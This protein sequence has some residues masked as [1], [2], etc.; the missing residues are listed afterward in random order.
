MRSAPFTV[1]V[2][3]FVVAVCAATATGKKT[4]AAYGYQQPY[5]ASSFGQRYTNEFKTLVASGMKALKAG[6]SRGVAILMR[7][8]KLKLNHWPNYELWDD[9]AVAECKRGEFEA[10]QWLLKSYRCAVNIWQ[11]RTA[12]HV[13]TYPNVVPNADLPPLCFRTFCG[14]VWQPARDEYGPTEGDATRD[15]GPDELERVDALLKSCRAG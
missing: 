2:L 3:A 1:V 12:C 6:D 11:A 15:P 9:I 4:E 7:A 14:D 13:G 10:A 8:A 5:A